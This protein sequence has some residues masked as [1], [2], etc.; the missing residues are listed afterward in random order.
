[1]WV[2][3]TYFSEI[4]RL[5]TFSVFFSFVHMTSKLSILCIYTEHP[6]GLA[7]CYVLPPFPVIL[8]LNLIPIFIGKLTS[9]IIICLLVGLIINFGSSEFCKS[10]TDYLCRNTTVFESINDI[11]LQFNCISYSCSNCMFFQ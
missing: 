4:I 9:N 6:K 2:L 10:F 5:H 1:M 7:P 3:P 11:K 8:D